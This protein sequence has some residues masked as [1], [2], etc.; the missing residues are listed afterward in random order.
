MTHIHRVIWL[1]VK[2]K[3]LPGSEKMATGST[4][5]TLAI[6]C[7]AALM[8]FAATEMA[9]A[10]DPGALPTGGRIVAGSGHID[11]SG[12]A[13]T[14][15]QQSDKMIANWET[16]NI[17]QGASVRFNQPAASSVAL[18]RI[19]D[20]NPSQILGSLSAN[21]R[22]FL[23][24][25]AGI[26][27]GQS[28]QVDVGGLVASTLDMTDA[29]FLAGA[30]HL[31]GNSSG[32]V[33]NRGVITTTDGGV[34]AFVGSRV[35]N[36]GSIRTPGG[37]AAL[38]AGEDVT[39]DFSGD[40]L[41]NY[42]VERGAIDAQAENQ[43]LIRAEGGMVVLT[44]KAADELTCAVVNN[45]G[46]IEAR[47]LINRGGRII[48]DAESGQTTVS[49]TLDVS[50]STVQGG[51]I[52]ATGDRVLVGS[53]AHLT[54][55]G[56]T[57]GGEVL[58]G[59]GWQGSDPSIHEA[60]NTLVEQGALLEASA[61]DHGNG[62]TVVVW[63][64][65]D[66][67]DSVTRVHGTLEA[68]GGPNGGDGGRIETSG[69]QLDVAG[70]QV[71]AA[72]LV[73]A[74][75]LW[76]L[77]P[78]DAVIDQ[79][80]AN[81]YAA[82][83]N[84]GTSVTN[85]VSGNITTS[86]NV[87]LLKSAGGDATLTLQATGYIALVD[88]SYIGSYTQDAANGY[89][90]SITS[91]SNKLHVVLNPDFDGNSSGGFWLP[92]SSSIVTNGGD[93]TIGGGAGASGAAVG[94]NANSYEW[95]SLM[96]GVAINGT[97]N[98][99]GGNI[100]M[101]G[102]GS[103]DPGVSAARGVH[104]GGTVTTT[105]TGTITITGTADGASAGIGMGGG[106]GTGSGTISAQNGNIILIGNK[107]TGTGV[108]QSLADSQ[109]TTTGTGNLSLTSTGE[110]Q[111]TGIFD[112]GGTTTLTAGANNITMTN[113]A[114][115]F[116]GAVSVVSG[117]TVAL[118]D[119]DSIT[120]GSCDV[121]G[122]LSVDALGFDLTV[123]GDL[124]KTSGGDATLT[125]NAVNTILVDGAISN[126][127]GSGK[128][129]VVLDAD[130]DSGTGDGAGIILLN[131]DI[132]TDGGS[133]SLGTGRT[134]S[135][136][137]VSTLVGGDVYVAGTG[138][139]TI[140]TNGG[141][142]DIRGE[143]IVANTNGL[144]VNSNGGNV[145]FYGLLNSGNSYSSVTS[146]GTTWSDAL[147]A[148]ASG[149]GDATGSTYLAT[150]TSRLENAVAGRV[151][152]YNPSWLG[153]RR[154]TGIG[155]DALWRWVTG[156][157][158]LEDGGNGLGFFT[159]NSTTGSGGT[160]Y[161]GGFSNWSTGEPNNYNGFAANP[162][163][164][165]ENESVLQ[166]TGTQG[167]WNDLTG[168]PSYDNVTAST[169]DYYVRETNLAASPVTVAAGTGTVTFSDAVGSSKALASLNVTSTGDIAID[170][171]VVTSEGT[172]SYTGNVTL[173]T[174][175]TILT[176]TNADTDFTVQTGKSITNASGGDAALTIKTTGNIVLD[177]GSAIT[178]STGQLDTVL[179]ADS[180]ATDGGYIHIKDSS[181]IKT[182][183]GAISFVGGTDGTGYAQGTSTQTTD[184]PHQDGISI[185]G[186]TL[187]SRVY[188]AGNPQTSG[189]GAITLKG[190]GYAG[191]LTLHGG[192]LWAGYG[193]IYTGGGDI[194]MD[195]Q[196]QENIGATE[197]G[198]RYG[199]FLD[200]MTISTNGG[201]VQI[202]TASPSTTWTGFYA[203]NTSSL[204]AGT[205]SIT[206]ST[207]QISL[208]GATISGTGTLT[209]QPITSDTTIGIAGGA[210]T[211]N[212]DATE[213]G[214]FQDGFSLITVG[215]ATAGAITVGGAT[216]CND[217]TTLRSNSTIAVNGAV[218]ANENLALTSNGAITQTQA[219]S[220]AGT[221]SIT[222]GTNDVTLTN[223]ANNFTGSVSVVSAGNLF[224]I[225]SD[226]LSLGTVSASGT[227]DI[228]TLT[229][230]L[231]LTG[232]VSTSDATASAI[233]LNAGE[234]T[235][236]G[237][238]T[239]GD[240][241]ISGGSVGTGAGGRA[242]L[243]SGSV[244]GSTGLTTLIG[245]GSGNFRYNSDET[246]TNFTTALGTGKYA[247]YRE[248]LTLTCTAENKI[249]TY[250]GTTPA[251]TTTLSGLQNGD[252]SGQAIST[253]ATVSVGG[254]TSTSGNYTA[255]DHT[256]TPSGAVGG[257]GYGF[258]YVNGTLTV[259]QKAITASG[260]T[261]ANKVYDTT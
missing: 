151:A 66:H 252:T 19:A 256:L 26:L 153:A 13:M 239:G 232:A 204:T 257:L 43:G 235:A 85:T 35:G 144:T 23:L 120:L 150:I 68:K 72:A 3:W 234:N 195:V 55:S 211:L 73:G 50:S 182:N 116:T 69:H 93:I 18:N 103:V 81:T 199:A 181:T 158:S 78:S 70:T 25:P 253:S 179:W 140:S 242:T 48:L 174:A 128:L 165:Q 162:D 191:N 214:Y 139:R 228:A 107:D 259:N 220:V 180:D 147:A 98:A 28:A 91:T 212:I 71:S 30:Y 246:T 118:K 187:D 8:L 83:L 251:L 188:I 222:A 40:G 164:T 111:G 138:A 173:G 101:N 7:L 215:S 60:T 12:H 190:K 210:G 34:I 146:I 177:A 134:A 52:V 92:D 129:D 38:I 21:G 227:V 171:G 6:G 192:G 124:T 15:N 155:T 219:L 95:N 137:G 51:T 175:E 218:T 224:L 36:E 14:I 255:G 172:Q 90:T 161:N 89:T 185:Y 169:L 141:A 53:G 17:G 142:V 22:I 49:G 58:V 4:R 229:G 223:T 104:I 76:L 230:D 24:N 135:I 176:Q 225:D 186:S 87:S 45:E 97:L 94:V 114:N 136:G 166:F 131:N 37:S 163:L 41:I 56:P 184:P 80:I 2:E 16:F 47:S 217:S 244:S 75:G 183:G 143:M 254:S 88:G 5:S 202:S 109:I 31:S 240:L 238:A 243:Y 33:L 196:A 170:G 159:Q 241:I 178:S 108:Q 62:G 32:S 96:R 197:G 149:A 221:T 133:L 203:G 27:F 231:T 148:A 119:A 127:S 65:V 59:G 54:A 233:T 245:S 77:D 132:T 79:T 20:R 121:S 236:A 154:V 42:R 260:I 247:I 106:T 99:Q 249:M 113:T 1:T 250:G 208:S 86:G 105:G 67:A 198:I 193:S 102:Q 152:N 248:Q 205:G 200:N 112:I 29:D 209:I 258:S 213:W 216:T 167:K 201:D 11:Q 126:T 125:L 100:V 63:S 206:L 160:A 226:T 189:G 122:D 156:P 64:D 157:E 145:R 46:V 168:G 117:G 261:A 237:T 39:L 194:V 74:G 61:T 130:N 207:D 44:A 10:L 82:T 123:T 57:G 115:D 9:L 110:V 84:T